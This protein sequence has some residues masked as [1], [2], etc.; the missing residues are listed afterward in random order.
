MKKNNKSIKK[1]LNLKEDYTLHLENYDAN[2]D[3][4]LSEGESTENQ[5][6]LEDG[7]SNEAKPAENDSG[8][9]PAGKSNVEVSRKPEGKGKVEVSPKKA[10]SATYEVSL[11]DVYATMKKAK[12]PADVGNALKAFLKTLQS[13]SIDALSKMQ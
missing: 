4:K 10:S 7:D 11:A 3:L 8:K 5:D 9:K 6:A 2:D 1:L 12:T 13:S